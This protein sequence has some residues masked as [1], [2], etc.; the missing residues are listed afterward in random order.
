MKRTLLLFLALAGTAFATNVGTQPVYQTADGNNNLAANLN[1]G[2]GV[3]L[4]GV[5]TFD[6]HAGTFLP[7]P[8]A[9]LV[10]NGTGGAGLL[11]LL[12]QSADP[13]AVANNILIYSDSSNKLSWVG[14]SGF[15]RSLDGTITASRSYTLPDA[16]GTVITTGNLSAITGALAGITS[17]DSL[18]IG[19]SGNSITFAGGSSLTDG[20]TGVLT[21]AAANAK[22][23][24]LSVGG[25]SSSSSVL[26][27][28]AMT[29]NFSG[30]TGTGGW[31]ALKIN[32]TDGAGTG[33]KFLLDLLLGGT[34]EFHVDSGGNVTPV[35]AFLAKTGSATAPGYAFASATT[36]GLYSGSGIG[37]TVAGASVGTWGT[38]SLNVTG[39]GFLAVAASGAPGIQLGSASGLS[40]GG[41][42]LEGMGFNNTGGVMAGA[43]YSSSTWTAT[44]T[45][46]EGI[47]LGIFAGQTN[48]YANTGLTAGNT[49]TPTAVM[50]FDATGKFTA[51]PPASS[52]SAWGSSGALFQFSGA[53]VTDSSTAASATAAL[54]AFYTF[55]APTLA[56]TNTSVVTTIAA[57]VYIGGAPSNGTNNTITNPYALYVASGNSYLGA[58]MSDAGSTAGSAAWKHGPIRTSSGLALDSTRGVQVSVGGTTIT[59]AVLT[60]NP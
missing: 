25:Y 58:S 60:T 17:I 56:A 50:S 44:A 28:F 15:K 57:T 42:I 22:T 20:G 43:Y 24:T 59:L 19:S 55:A 5:G 30:Q 3:T 32:A 18:A 23:I 54:E 9:A 46:M 33:S 12:S 26:N 52:R 34:E 47:Y 31:T 6:F 21:I 11:Q 2:A 16:S 10:I 45:S 41:L 53:T 1:V 39:S 51:T 29:P 4:G 14:A 40:N 27:S 35:G 48:F 8:V 36:T 38:T 7:P 37:F 13:A 49:F